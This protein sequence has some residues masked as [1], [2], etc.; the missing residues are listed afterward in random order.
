MIY[1]KTPYEIYVNNEP[2]DIAVDIEFRKKQDKEYCCF[3]SDRPHFIRGHMLEEKDN[4]FTW[5]KEN[6]DGE[7]DFDMVFSPCT[8]LEH[9][10]K[11]WRAEMIGNIP[12]F[13]TDKEMEEWLYKT[14]LKCY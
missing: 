13:K 7:K 2:F 5:R 10:N 6:E 3:V 4:T 14:I 8:S 1:A 9:F 12:D 11:V